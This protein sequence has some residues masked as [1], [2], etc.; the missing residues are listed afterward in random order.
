MVNLILGEE[1]LK[2]S[3]LSTT[4]TICELKYGEERRIVVHFKD[5]D[6]E[7]MLPIKEF[8]L[9]D[10]SSEQS[11][12]Q[13]ISPFVHATSDRDRGSLYKKVELF[14]PHELLE[15][16][17][18]NFVVDILEPFILRGNRKSCIWG[19]NGRR[20]FG[21][22]TGGQYNYTKRVLESFLLDV[23]LFYGFLSAIR[24][25]QQKK[26]KQCVLGFG[27]PLK[28]GKGKRELSHRDEQK[29]VNMKLGRLR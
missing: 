9:K 24:V 15:V 14:W 27:L 20:G 1:L 4:S 28:R 12:L 13:Q 22:L 26:A 5:K 17:V 7:T 16:L 10:E 25:F 18:C 3:A 8:R 6:P 2:Y 19:S 23:K 29:V 11:Y 21:H